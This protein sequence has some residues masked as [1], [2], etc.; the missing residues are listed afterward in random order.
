MATVLMEI[1]VCLSLWSGLS[2][3]ILP[4]AV[5]YMSREELKTFSGRDVYAVYNYPRQTIFMGVDS[6]YILAHEVWHY[7]QDVHG[8]PFYEAPAYEAAI[9]YM[10]Y[11]AAS[12]WPS[13]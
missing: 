8:L 12:Q 11:C 4:P 10:Q 6:D 7:F 9:Y 13:E 2:V 1:M 3:P 5:E